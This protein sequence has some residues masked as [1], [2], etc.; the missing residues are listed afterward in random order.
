MYHLINKVVS[1]LLYIVQKFYTQLRLFLHGYAFLTAYQLIIRNFF[2]HF[3]LFQTEFLPV[4]INQV[5]KFLILIFSLKIGEGILLFYTCFLGALLF[6]SSIS[7]F[8]N[9][10]PNVIQLFNK[11]IVFFRLVVTVI[12]SSTISFF[13][14]YHTFFI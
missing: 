13:I 12:I 6:V 2:P 9:W 14:R 10:I 11:S 4:A 1:I 8:A 7:Y 3:Y 5:I